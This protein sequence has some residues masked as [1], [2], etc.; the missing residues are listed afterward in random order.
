M[1]FYALMDADQNVVQ[2]FS[3]STRDAEEYLRFLQSRRL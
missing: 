2:T 1:P 3:G